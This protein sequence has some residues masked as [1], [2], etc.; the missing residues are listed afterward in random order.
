MFSST[1]FV[2]LTY[3]QSPICRGVEGLTPSVKLLGS[4]S[5]HLIFLLN[6]NEFLTNQNQR[7]LNYIIFDAYSIE[8]YSRD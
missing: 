2:F 4:K 6:F 5:R 1:A 8:S 3:M 7:C